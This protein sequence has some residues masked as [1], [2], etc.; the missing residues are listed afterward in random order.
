[1][2]LDWGA[3]QE[4]FNEVFYKLEE[5]I[6]QPI[7]LNAF[8]RDEDI[9]KKRNIK[10]DEW[11]DF[12]VAEGD[13]CR[14]FDQPLESDEHRNTVADVDS[15]LQALNAQMATERHRLRPQSDIEFRFNLLHRIFDRLTVVKIYADL[16]ALDFVLVL[17][18]DIFGC[19]SCIQA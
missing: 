12:G 15:G 10:Q 16:I 7:Q 8:K 13:G 3:W 6:R 2:P 4:D 1:M 14:R 5:T 9:T 19:L 17:F 18:V 11:V